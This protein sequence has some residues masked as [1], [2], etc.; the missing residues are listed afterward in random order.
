MVW[1]TPEQQILLA[2]DREKGTEVWRRDFGPY[3]AQHGSGASPI[4]VDDVVI[5]PSDQRE[6]SFVVAVDRATGVT[7]WK[8]NVP[9]KKGGYA[10]PCIYRPSVGNP[11]LILS[12]SAYGVISLDPYTGKRAWDIRLFK[13]R[14]VHSPIVASG[15]IIVSSGEGGRGTRT[16]VVRPGNPAKGVAPAIA[17]E[18]GESRPYVCT[19]V[20]RGDLLFLWFDLGVV[21]CV[22]APSGEVLWRERIGENFFGSP[23]R[24]ADKLYCISRKGE[25]VV[26]AAADEFKLLGRI[27]LEE[28]SNSTPAVADGVMYLRTA[29]HLMAI[30]GS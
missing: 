11:Q 28:P 7:R 25:L 9:V 5:L 27:D 21:T 26:L 23:V 16:V 6:G 24:V 4:V 2:L 29:S 20:T 17:Y 13:D 3:L 30:G 22:D 1:T 15:L 14:V 18:V 10:T 8:T 12:G 19:P